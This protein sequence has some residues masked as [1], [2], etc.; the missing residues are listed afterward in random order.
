M[1]MKTYKSSVA[2]LFLIFG[3]AWSGSC[4]GQSFADMKMLPTVSLSLKKPTTLL[5]A[6]AITQVEMLDARPDD[7][8]LGFMRKGE[9]LTGQREEMTNDKRVLELFGYYVPITS[10]DSL[11]ELLKNHL[12]IG[13]QAMPDTGLTVLICLRECW[14]FE[15]DMDANPSSGTTVKMELDNSGLLFRADVYIKK[16]NKYIPFARMDTV[17]HAGKPLE[18]EAK[19][20]LSNAIVSLADKINHSNPTN[21]FARATKF[22]T[23]SSIDSFYAQSHRI[24]AVFSTDSVNDYI[25][26]DW[27]ALKNKQLTPAHLRYETDKLGDYFY[28]K[29]NN[30]NELPVSSLVVIKAGN[31][32]VRT[33]NT[34]SKVFV[35]NNRMFTMGTKMIGKRKIYTPPIMLPVGSSWLGSTGGT[36]AGTKNRRFHQPLMIDMESEGFF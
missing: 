32:Y 8:C 31:L 15:N 34:F 7:Y 27:Q 33:K 2:L 19:S 10:Q 26:E 12:I 35:H 5:L 29:D 17:F 13:N 18:K 4:Y 3:C 14:M 36:H 16:E 23:R 28:N 11:H 22:K 6:P 21:V 20:L 1:N 24:P 25:I 9:V 30:G